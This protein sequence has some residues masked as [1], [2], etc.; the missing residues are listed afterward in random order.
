[1][2]M[3]KNTE[4]MKCVALTVVNNKDIKGKERKCQGNI[5]DQINETKCG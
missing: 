2:F 4:M 5:H 1:M 3:M